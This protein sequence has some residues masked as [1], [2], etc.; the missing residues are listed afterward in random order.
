MNST[1]FNLLEA[2]R[3]LM[4]VLCSAA[5]C[6]AAF[7]WTTLVVLYFNGEKYQA[8]VLNS[9]RTNFNDCAADFY[10]G[11]GSLFPKSI[12]DFGIFNSRITDIDRDFIH[13]I[14]GVPT[15]A[16]PC[17]FPFKAGT[18]LRVKA[19]P[20][21]PFA[22]IETSPFINLH[23]PICLT[24]LGVFSFWIVRILGRYV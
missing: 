22:Y 9:P 6:L 10:R 13:F 24:I 23:L 19:V 17:I 16:H 21:I 18:I 14:V 8:T 3:G 4:F 15:H 12:I 2:I 11:Q 1:G 7:S 5:I 20:A